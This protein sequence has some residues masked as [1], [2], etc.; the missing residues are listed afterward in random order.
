MPLL[1]ESGNEAY[2]AQLA[3]VTGTPYEVHGAQTTRLPFLAMD[4][5]P[6]SRHR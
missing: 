2:A 4:P 3:A 5:F 6:W 1:R